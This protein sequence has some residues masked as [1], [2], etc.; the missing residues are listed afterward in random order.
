[1]P[2]GTFPL[3]SLAWG[4]LDLVQPS[5]EVMDILLSLETEP[6]DV[7]ELR[8]KERERGDKGGTIERV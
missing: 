7:T 2:V 8:L 6:E 4:C 5:S 3:G 1:M